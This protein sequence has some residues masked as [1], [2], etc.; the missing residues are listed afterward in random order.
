MRLAFLFLSFVWLSVHAMAAQAAPMTFQIYE[1]SSD[2]SGCIIVAGNGEVTAT[3]ASTLRALAKTHRL[4][5]N[6]RTV[7]VLNSPGGSL[8]GGL[9]LGREIRSQGFD[10][11]IGRVSLARGGSSTVDSG[12]CASAC[13][14]AFL[15]GSQRSIGSESRYGLHQLSVA[16][17]EAVSLEEA[18]RSTQGVLAEINRYVR[19]MGASPEIVTLAT[20]TSADSIHWVSYS[21]ITSL[22]ISNA[23]GLVSQ[24]PWKMNNWPTH[25]SVWSTTPSGTRE[26]FLIT[27]D[28]YPIG[29]SRGSISMS[30]SIYRAPK[31]DT[32]GRSYARAVVN[33]TA[34]IVTK[35]LGESMA[36]FDKQGTIIGNFKVPFRLL[37]TMVLSGR[38]ISLHF[39]S[40]A[41][42]SEHLEPGSHSLPTQGLGSALDVMAAE[43]PH[44]VS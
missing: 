41:D 39:Q 9:A 8:M 40:D 11:H 30:V 13:A 5:F 33:M 14:Y 35:P 18:V 12:E 42:L 26:L 19:E 24:K 29:G 16:S 20:E 4:G 10:T 32:M 23:Q 7:V 37:R 34:G 43:C 6:R 15:G 21:K 28:R 38:S 36:T 27:C 22:R 2:C 3:T 1:N 44:L 25:F 17:D 31:E